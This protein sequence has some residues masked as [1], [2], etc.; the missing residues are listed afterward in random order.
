MVWERKAYPHPHPHPHQTFISPSP[1]LHLTLTLTRQMVL[2]RKAR[3]GNFEPKLSA[4]Q[5]ETSMRAND[6]WKQL[7][8]LQRKAKTW[9]MRSHG[10]WRRAYVGHAQPWGTWSLRARGSARAQPGARLA[11]GHLTLLDK[12]EGKNIRG[13]MVYMHGS[14][15]LTWHNI[16]YCRMAA[17]FSFV[18][19]APDEMA[20]GEFRT[21]A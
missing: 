13:V 7:V 12:L 4:A 18:V 17:A 19:I 1:N 9:V 5:Q 21:R 10:E 6:S 20:G 3:E 2:E 8:Y 11:A 16:R 15:G 14:G